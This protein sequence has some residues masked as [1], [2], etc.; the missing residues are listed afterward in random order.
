MNI[1]SRKTR[2]RLL[3]TFSVLTAVTTVLSLSGV[4]YLAYGAT[5]SD[6]GL[7]EGDL[8]SAAGSDDPDVYIVN[9]MGYKRLFLNPEIFN[10]YGHLGGFAAVKNVSPATR[11]AFMTSGLFRVDGDEK[12]YGLESTGE[13]VAN[14]RWVN[15][16]G[17]QAVADDANFFKKV[18]VINAAEKA[19]YNTGAD[20]TSV[21]QVPAYTRGG[22]V[23]VATGPLSVMVAPGNPG[24]QT[25]TLNAIG[26]EMLR[27]R[28]SGS[29]T[30]NTLTV[31]RSGPGDTGDFGNVYVYDGATRLTSGKSFSSS[32]GTAT[33]LVN[34]AVS[35]TK[36]L[37]II[38]DMSTG[39]PGNVNYASL[40]TVT[41][42]GGASVSGLPV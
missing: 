29:G 39:T 21:T 41:L 30:I 35:G 11:D 8:I 25:I 12:V 17:A 38:A 23:P 37:S 26:V 19:L 42:S 2:E 7:K 20:F 14:L 4:A 10:L 32:D 3:K 33:F 6:Y 28:A 18:F 5:P 9:E 24:A 16:S 27:F 1:V 22:S 15:T 40:T 34:V 36:D 31:K 13:D